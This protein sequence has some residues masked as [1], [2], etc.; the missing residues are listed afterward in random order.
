M[1]GIFRLI[2]YN[3]KIIKA[4]TSVDGS[5]DDKSLE[6]VRT[7]DQMITVKYA[8]AG[9]SDDSASRCRQHYHHWL[10]NTANCYYDNLRN[11][12]PCSPNLWPQSILVR[13]TPI[14]HAVASVTCLVLGCC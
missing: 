4:P 6:K 10:A 5:A 13:E 9:K 1:G 2:L 7:F 14:G 12:R 3:D 11:S 8:N